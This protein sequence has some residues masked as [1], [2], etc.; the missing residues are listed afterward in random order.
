MEHLG[1]GSYAKSTETGPAVPKR[2]GGALAAAFGTVDNR[3]LDTTCPD[4]IPNPGPGAYRAKHTREFTSLTPHEIRALKPD[5]VFA[6]GNPRKNL[7]MGDT[8]IPAPGD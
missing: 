7:A 3:K 8:S 4:N 6:S 5:S 2:F 1:P